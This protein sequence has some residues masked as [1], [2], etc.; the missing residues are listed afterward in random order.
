MEPFGA[1]FSIISF[2]PPYAPTGSPPPITLPKH[3]IS[4][5]IP[6]Y[7]CAQWYPTRKPVI[8]SSK[9]SNEPY[10]CVLSRKDCRKFPS[11][12]TTPIF[13]ETGS[14]ITAAISFPYNSNAFSTLAVSLY[15][16]VTVFFAIPS[17]TPGLSGNPNVATPEPALINNESP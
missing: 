4:G 11:G 16:T 9:I 5:S 2:L 6:K 10:D 12:G 8:T 3:V 1:T 17:G 7:P 14:T 13:P 15:G